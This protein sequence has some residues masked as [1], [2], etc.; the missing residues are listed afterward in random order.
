MLSPLLFA[1]VMDVVTEGVREGLLEEI[2]LRMY[3]ESFINR[4]THPK[5]KE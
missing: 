5:E 2:L 1:I 4:R 3:A